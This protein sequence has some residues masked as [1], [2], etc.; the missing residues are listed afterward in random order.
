MLINYNS[1]NEALNKRLKEQISKK[2]DSSIEY[3]LRD[4]ETICKFYDYSLVI[5]EFEIKVYPIKDD[6]ITPKISYLKY[7]LDSFYM[8]NQEKALS[9]GIDYVCKEILLLKM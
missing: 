5:S 9:I 1:I 2:I 8:D 3:C 7:I 6:F 4:L